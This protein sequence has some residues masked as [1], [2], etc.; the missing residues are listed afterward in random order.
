MPPLAKSASSYP[1]ADPHSRQIAPTLVQDST[2]SDCVTSV[3]VL[4]CKPLGPPQSNR[5][6]TRLGD[7]DLE[8]L[9]EVV[10]FGVEVEGHGG[11]PVFLVAESSRYQF[12]RGTRTPV[13]DRFWDYF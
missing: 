12:T 13:S 4:L 10:L 5:H 9:V 8:F 1:L 3:V 7:A 6:H 11:S 2:L